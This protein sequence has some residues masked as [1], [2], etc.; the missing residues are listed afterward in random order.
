M[1]IGLFGGSFDPP[2]YG[3]LIFAEEAR[4]TLKLDRVL[5]MPAYRSPFKPEEQGATAETR[6]ELV[7]LAVHDNP[8]FDLNIFEAARKETSFTVDTLRHLKKEFPGDTLYLLVG[9][10]A[11]AE[12]KDWKEPEEILA[13][14]RIAVALRPGSPMDVRTLPFGDRV[15][16]FPM[17]LIDISAS[18]IRARV[19]AG[20][21][22]LYLVPWQVKT[23]IEYMGLYK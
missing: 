16:T 7:E 18:D 6:A 3:H 5:F 14:A 11:F 22:I 21:S 4:E 9:A 1:R 17:P 12:F 13:L 23:F 20:R 10:D 2:H 15:E 8:H 19:K